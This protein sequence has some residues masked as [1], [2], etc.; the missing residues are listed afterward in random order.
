[1]K[2]ANWIFIDS[3]TSEIFCERCGEREK[4]KLPMPIT[5]FVKWS[6]Y[7]GSKHEYCKEKRSCYDKNTI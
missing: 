3:K 5:A 1:M 4:S 6:E 7:F 2:I